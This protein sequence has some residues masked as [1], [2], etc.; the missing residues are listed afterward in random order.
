MN[1]KAITVLPKA[2]L[3]LG[4]KMPVWYE[5]RLFQIGFLIDQFKIVK[6]PINPDG[7]DM[8]CDA[9]EQSLMQLFAAYE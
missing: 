8:S 3:E 6:G 7:I 9:T 5:Q 1:T 4:A 2:I